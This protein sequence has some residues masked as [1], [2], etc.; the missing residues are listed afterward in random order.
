M[1]CNGIPYLRLSVNTQDP[2]ESFFG[3]IKGMFGYEARPPLT[4]FNKRMDH[5]IIGKLLEEEKVDIF[6]VQKAVEG[7]YPDFEDE[8]FDFINAEG[9]GPWTNAELL[10]EVCL[11]DDA[12]KD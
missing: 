2:L 9:Q 1:K 11:S 7:N 4:N 3:V 6:D 5:Y 12:Q 8:K 10:D